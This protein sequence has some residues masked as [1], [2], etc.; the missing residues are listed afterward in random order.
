[1]LNT[2]I[3]VYK[4]K[5]YDRKNFIFLTNF[6]GWSFNSFIYNFCN[7]NILTVL[8]GIV[9]LSPLF[10]KIKGFGFKFSKLK[11]LKLLIIR[12][13]ITNRILFNCPIN[14]SFVTFNK[15][16]VLLLSRNIH[17][18]KAKLAKFVFYFK[19]FRYKKLGIFMMSLQ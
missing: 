1:M 13:N 18:L 3:I 12:A 16:K 14:I 15:R 5:D 9:S 11:I 4:I 19:K 6:M 2:S 10:I 17:F 8:Y 7:N